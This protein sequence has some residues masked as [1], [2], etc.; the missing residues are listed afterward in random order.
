MARVSGAVLLVFG[1]GFAALSLWMIERQL[2]LRGTIERDAAVFLAVA[3]V[4]C[5]F[6][7][8]VG[9][10]LAFNRPNRYNSILSP[11]SWTVLAASLGS[12][13]IG[14]VY[15][16]LVQQQYLGAFF[17]L[18]FGIAFVY[19]CTKARRR[20]LGEDRLRGAP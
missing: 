17:C 11:T 4:L 14:L 16:S 6:C 13:S 7:C 8:T 9:Y 3:S 5:A 2:S 18:A 20:A 19:G 1:I 12:I 15:L 10:R